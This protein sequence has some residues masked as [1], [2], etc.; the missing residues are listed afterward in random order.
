M[1]FGAFFV[2][3][4]ARRLRSAEDCGRAIVASFFVFSGTLEPDT[5]PTA[6][7]SGVLENKSEKSSSMPSSRRASSI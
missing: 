4:E 7:T 1:S 3:I 5:V 6:L 2:L